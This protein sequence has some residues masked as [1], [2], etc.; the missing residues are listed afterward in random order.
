MLAKKITCTNFNGEEII[1]TCYF[2]LSKAELVEMELTTEGGLK[3]R[4]QAMVD[5][6]DRKK[7]ITVF[8]S[9]IVMAYGE[10]SDD[11]RF[12]MKGEDHELGKKFTQSAA[13]DSLL[14]E[15]LGSEKACADFFINIIPKEMVASV[16]EELAKESSLKIDAKD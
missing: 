15:L 5:T 6:K 9:I 8:K 3:D 12:L 13:Y 2:N 4:L 16:K 10:K 7:L 11:G 1:E 14:M